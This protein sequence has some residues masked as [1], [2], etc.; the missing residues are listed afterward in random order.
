LAITYKFFALSL[1]LAVAGL[2]V[3]GFV[4]DIQD[5]FEEEEETGL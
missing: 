3:G 4:G 1:Q 2:F 5:C